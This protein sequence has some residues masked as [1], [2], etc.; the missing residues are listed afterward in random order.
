MKIKKLVCDICG[1]DISDVPRKYKFKR[2]ESTPFN[3]D[4]WEFSK[5]SKLDMCMGCYRH[6]KDF[7]KQR[8]EERD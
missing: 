6:F 7:V 4:D 3:C 8:K 1:E 2:Y 5:W